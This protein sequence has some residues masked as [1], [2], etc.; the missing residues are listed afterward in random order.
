MSGRILC[1]FS[2]STSSNVVRWSTTACSD[3]WSDAGWKNRLS[4]SSCSHRWHSGLRGQLLLLVS[5]VDEWSHLAKE[6]LYTLLRPLK[7][8]L[9]LPVLPLVLIELVHESLF[10]HLFLL[11]SRTSRVL[12]S[13]LLSLPLYLISVILSNLT[14]ITLLKL[15]VDVL[16]WFLIIWQF[17]LVFIYLFLKH[18]YVSDNLAFDFSY[19][20]AH[21][22]H[23]PAAEHGV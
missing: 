8:I 11:G 12:L 16:K 5:H 7:F 18:F 15:T 2:T 17:P 13:V 22:S 4:L 9:Q 20:V 23:F 21:A 6:L 3:Y 14:R 19:L 1:A 10:L